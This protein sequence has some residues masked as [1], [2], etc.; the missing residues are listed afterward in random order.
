LVEAVAIALLGLLVTGLLK[1]HAEILRRLHELGADLDGNST[2]R[3][4]PTPFQLRPDISAPRHAG[5]SAFELSGQTPAGETAVISVRGV[6]TATLLAF[7]SS[8]CVTCDSFWRV[9]QDP[10][11]LGLPPHTRLVVVT[12]DADEESSSR[13]RE[14]AG[15]QTTVLMSSGGWVDYKVPSSPYFILISGTDGMVVGEGSAARWPDVRSL[16]TQALDDRA[17]ASHSS[18]TRRK[19]DALGLDRVDADLFSAGIH[20]GHPSLYGPGG[21]SAT[22]DHDN[23]DVSQTSPG[24]S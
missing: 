21:G 5:T 13:I 15:D 22:S 6:G 12:K 11:G 8:G 3:L 24:D 10:R 23:G 16:M 4:P 17:S 19:G 9:F 1:S 2:S 14:L 7:L 20:P 18:T